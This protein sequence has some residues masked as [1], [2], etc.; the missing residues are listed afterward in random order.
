[1]R[2]EFI[3]L[4]KGEH[5]TICGHNCVGLYEITKKK[6]KKEEEIRIFML[7]I[8]T[9]AYV[10]KRLVLAKMSASGDDLSGILHTEHISF[11]K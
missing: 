10:R 7:F 2:V 6:K 8:C 3:T 11:S 5:A 1:M 9:R 4:M